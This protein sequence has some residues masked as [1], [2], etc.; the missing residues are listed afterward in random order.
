M[1]CKILLLLA[2]F[3]LLLSP[4]QITGYEENKTLDLLLLPISEMF[5]EL[6]RGLS[7]FRRWEIIVALTL[8]D[9]FFHTST[10]VSQ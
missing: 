3:V 1:L 2:D 7:Y 8:A 9:L 4:I 10:A 6:L 5:Q